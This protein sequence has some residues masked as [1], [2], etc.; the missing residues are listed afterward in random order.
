MAK[1]N[2]SFRIPLL[3]GTPVG[4]LLAGGARAFTRDHAHG[5]ETA[6][7]PASSSSGAP[8]AKV[9]ERQRGFSNQSTK[10]FDQA[11][12]CRS[13]VAC[14]RHISH[15]RVPPNWSHRDW[16]CEIRAQTAAAAWQAACDY[17]ASRGVP[18]E[19]FVRE[20]VNESALG[21]YRREWR[22]VIRHGS[23]RRGPN[24]EEPR[25]EVVD[26]D[27]VASLREAVKLLSPPE[28]RLIH[29]GS[30]LAG[31][32]RGFRRRALRSQPAGGQ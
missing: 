7:S 14:L 28:K 27:L 6:P 12:A 3:A 31:A 24:N 5:N 4:K 1:G 2:R 25:T 22:Y 21:R 20:R 26:S 23:V 30:L 32:N 17:D 15:W 13:T 8:R 10:R 11:L 19:A 29:S 18:F 16:S 9:D